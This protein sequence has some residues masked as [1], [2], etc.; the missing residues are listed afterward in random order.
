MPFH[1]WKCS[2]SDARRTPLRHLDSRKTKPDSLRCIWQFHI[3]PPWS[4]K[5]SIPRD[6]TANLAQFATALF[7]EIGY[8]RVARLARKHQMSVTQR[9]AIL[10]SV[11][12][13]L[14]LSVVSSHKLAAGVAL[15]TLRLATQVSVIEQAHCVHAANG[16]ECNLQFSQALAIGAEN[17]LA[18]VFQRVTESPNKTAV[19]AFEK[20]G[21]RVINFLL[22]DP[23]DLGTVF[24]S[25]D[26]SPQS[27]EQLLRNVGTDVYA[28]CVQISVVDFLL[29]VP[30]SKFIAPQESVLFRSKTQL[31]QGPPYALTNILIKVANLSR[32]WHSIK[33]DRRE[34]Q[35]RDDD[36]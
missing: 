32:R 36:L 20:I 35:L 10:V 17:V 28:M 4:V 24:L 30:T 16:V 19:L 1:I 29:G 11:K 33:I 5:D 21:G 15:S 3:R 6:L 34:V 31:R 23:D 8:R 25:A 27:S 2:I 26:F 13:A 7:L 9:T 22:F 18:C 14:M 12:L